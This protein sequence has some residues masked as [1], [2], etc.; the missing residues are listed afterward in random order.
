MDDV[1]LLRR[2]AAGDE[3]AFQELVSTN[4]E[5]AFDGEEQSSDDVRSTLDHDDHLP[6]DDLGTR[7]RTYTS[8][9]LGN[10]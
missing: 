4:P 2:Y 6:C 8:H 9:I 1:R 10:W 5:S 7:G 3:G